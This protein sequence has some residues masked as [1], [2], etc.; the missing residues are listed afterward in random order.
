MFKFGFSGDDI[1]DVEVDDTDSG[2]ST[3]EEIAGPNAAAT[4]IA[5]DT[6]LYDIVDLVSISGGII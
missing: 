3:V 2:E 4:V 1:N 5:G 6:E